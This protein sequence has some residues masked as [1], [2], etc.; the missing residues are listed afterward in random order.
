MV[1]VETA[2]AREQ[3]QLIRDWE[4]DGAGRRKPGTDQP[5]PLDANPRR[6][7]QESVGLGIDFTSLQLF[8]F[9]LAGL[10][11]VTLLHTLYPLANNA[12]SSVFTQTFTT[13]LVREA[14]VLLVCL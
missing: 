12:S 8:A 5:F 2:V 1:S 11:V 14:Q 6:I 13:Y 9:L 10:A 7:G 4:R 3:K